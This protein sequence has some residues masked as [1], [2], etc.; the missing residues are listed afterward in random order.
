M[1]VLRL[2]GHSFV[3]DW[4][5]RDA[6][7]VDL[8]ATD[9]DFARDA[10]ARFGCRVWAVEAV[11]E[12][13][14]RLKGRAGLVAEHAAVGGRE[15]FVELRTFHGRYASAVLEAPTP[16]QGSVRV[17]ATTLEAFLARHGLTRVD[18]LK[19][20][21]EGS[22]LEMFAATSDRTLQ[23]CVQMTVEFHDFED[24]AMAPRVREADARLRALGFQRLAFTLDNSDVLYVNTAVHRV[25]WLSRLWMIPRY[26]YWT[27][28]VRRAGRLARRLAKRPHGQ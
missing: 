26:K 9:G 10:I 8:G 1:R 5:S 28:L 21:I 14:E 16:L 24:A 25:G 27:A 13:A 17:P 7:V 22:E 2:Q 12:L 15:G 23:S 4:L 6:I 3:A 20:D 11:P 18:L 19:V